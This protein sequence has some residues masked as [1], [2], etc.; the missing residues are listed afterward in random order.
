LFVLRPA[1]SVS[2]EPTEYL[3][4]WRIVTLADGERHFCGCRANGTTVRVSS[5]I[6]QFNTE[7]KIGMTRSGRIYQLEGP[8]GDVEVLRL[9]VTVWCLSN[10]TDPVWMR[11]D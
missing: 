7:T 11:F 2:D 4:H 6:I 9:A 10:E 3:Y 1:A 5:A 8:P